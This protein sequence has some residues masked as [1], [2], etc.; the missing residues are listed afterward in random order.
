MKL[1]GLFEALDLKSAVD[2]G[3]VR[4]QRHPELP[5]LIYNYTEHTQYERAWTSVTTQCRGLI[6][7]EQGQIVARPWAKFFNYGE[8]AEVQLDLDAPVEVT[9]KLDGSLGILYRAGD[10]WAIATRGSFASEQALHATKVLRDKYA[11]FEPPAGHTVLFEIVYPGNRIVVDYM[12]LD[13]LLLLGSVDIETGQTFGPGEVPGWPGPRTDV[14]SART[15]A[16][17]LAMPARD[18][19]EGVVVRFPGTGVQ[20]KIKLAAYV[21]LHRLVTGLN[22]RVVWERLGAGETA[23]EICEKLPD[24]FHAWVR[25]LAGELDSA[26]A[27]ILSNATDEH[28]A[29]LARLGDGFSRKD[30]AM[31]AQRSPLRG[32]LFMLLDGKDPMPKI[33]ASIKPSG[34]RSMVNHSEDVA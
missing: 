20:V 27:E 11:A 21:A 30:Y 7:D 33:W 9:D 14:L 17:A 15:L 13:D 10:G 24:E 16:E 4:V 12:G 3:F 26:A 34:A 28:T 18:N 1:D 8:Q 5:L 32:W 22:A 25:D 19:A 23:A 2:E 6:A 31:Q 29:L